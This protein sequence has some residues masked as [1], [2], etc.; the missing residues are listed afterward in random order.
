MSYIPYNSSRRSGTANPAK[1][2]LRKALPAGTLIASF[3]FIAG[4]LV[5]L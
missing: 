1:P 3:F 5:F 2:D 4:L